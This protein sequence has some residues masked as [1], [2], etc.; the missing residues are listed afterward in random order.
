MEANEVFIEAGFRSHPGFP[1]LRLVF[2]FLLKSVKVILYISKLIQ[3]KSNK[4]KY[5]KNLVFSQLKFVQCCFG[6]VRR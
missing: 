2:F 6:N 1:L 4:I 5:K 3:L